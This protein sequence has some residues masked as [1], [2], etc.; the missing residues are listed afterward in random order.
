MSKERICP[1]S[2]QECWGFCCTWW[3][4][5]TESCYSAALPTAADSLT[6]I[7]ITPPLE[8]LF[9]DEDELNEL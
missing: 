7:S 4:A 3:D 2:Q 5:E 8:T 1:I 9:A 6:K